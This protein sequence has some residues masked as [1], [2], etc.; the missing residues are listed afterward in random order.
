MKVRLLASPGVLPSTPTN[1]QRDFVPLRQRT[2][3]YRSE[4]FG[5][6]AHPPPRVTMETNKKKKKKD[7]ALFMATIVPFPGDFVKR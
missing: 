5:K 4:T 7:S 6:V 1:E 3:T 2:F